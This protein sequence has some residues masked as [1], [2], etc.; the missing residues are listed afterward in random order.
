LLE[1]SRIAAGFQDRVVE[2]SGEVVAVEEWLP[3]ELLERGSH[4]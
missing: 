2:P 4:T 3:A 1:W